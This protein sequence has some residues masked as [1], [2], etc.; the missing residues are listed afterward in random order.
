MVQVHKS[1]RTY[2]YLRWF[3]DID[4]Q[5]STVWRD[6]VLSEVTNRWRAEMTSVHR[7]LV[8][9]LKISIAGIN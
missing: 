9:E 6:P 7:Y 2:A 3:W 4:V 5:V 1:K 8:T